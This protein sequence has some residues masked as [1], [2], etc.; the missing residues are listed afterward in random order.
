MLVASACGAS[1]PSSGVVATQTGTAP[2]SG[3]PSTAPTSDGPSATTPASSATPDHTPAATQDAT[4]TPDATPTD[5]SS[6]A[7]SGSD[8]PSPS[9]ALACNPRGNSATFWPQT[10]SSVT[11]GV[12]CAVLPKGWFVKTGNSHYAGGG[13][14]TITYAGPAGATVSLSEGSFCTDGS[15]CV[16]SGTA[17]GDAMFGDMSASLVATDAGG[18]AIVAAQGETPSW[19]MVTSGLDKPTTLS[20]G[21]ALARVGG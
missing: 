20:F 12:Y 3:A 17:A 2:A 9:I 15:G 16:P 10:A 21:A 1:G 11:W 4:A 14:L 13:S 18:F 19:L 6:A 8:A 5:G 7:P